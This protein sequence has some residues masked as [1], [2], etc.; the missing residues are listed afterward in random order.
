MAEPKKRLTSTR[1]GNRRSH[2]A[3]AS[4]KLTKCQQ[5]AEP[6]PSHQVCP[7]CGTYKGKKVIDVDKKAKRATKKG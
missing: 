7:V 4:L 5:C 3:L 1:S 2:L 6:V